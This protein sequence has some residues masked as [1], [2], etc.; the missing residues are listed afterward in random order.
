MSIG[1]GTVNDVIITVMPQ[2]ANAHTIANASAAQTI[3]A[4]GPD[5]LS[6]GKAMALGCVGLLGVLTIVLGT[7]FM[8]GRIKNG[9]GESI[10]FQLG[11]IVLGVIVVS[12]VGIAAALTDWTVDQGVVDRRYV[13]NEWGR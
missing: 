5:I 10:M 9:I 13:H 4:L 1:R 12:S 7:V 2:L 8:I 6:N 11:V 3:S